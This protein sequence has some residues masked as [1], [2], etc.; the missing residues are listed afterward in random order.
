MT[1]YVAI[2]DHDG[3]GRSYGMPWYKEKLYD[4]RSLHINDGW[5]LLWQELTM[6]AISGKNTRVSTLIFPTQ[7]S[8]SSQL[9][10]REA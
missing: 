2:L 6:S 5:L 4:H 1:G 8:S 9:Q 7:P 3:F 10:N